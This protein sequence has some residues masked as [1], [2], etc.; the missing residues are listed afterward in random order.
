MSGVKIP[1]RQLS[2]KLI[3]QGRADGDVSTESIKR[4]DAIRS[5]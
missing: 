1:L 4:V 3:D 5:H 2:N